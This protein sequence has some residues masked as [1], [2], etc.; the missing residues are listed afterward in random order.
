MQILRDNDIAGII[1]GCGGDLNCATRHASLP[2][3]EN[4]RL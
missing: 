4:E 2:R 3:R 1:A